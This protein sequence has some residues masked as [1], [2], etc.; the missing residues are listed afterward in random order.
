VYEVSYSKINN[1]DWRQTY[2]L[3]RRDCDIDYIDRKGERRIHWC[4]WI[5]W[6][7]RDCKGETSVRRRGG[8]LGYVNFHHS[9]DEGEPRWFFAWVSG[10]RGESVSNGKCYSNEREARRAVER[11]H[12]GLTR[13]WHIG[14][15]ASECTAPYISG[16]AIYCLP[17]G[18]D[19]VQVKRDG[20][21][22][23]EMRP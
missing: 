7:R 2:A 15:T 20:S 1:F 11:Y 22:V 16:G 4:G 18:D 12:R 21:V 10:P 14:K 19:P 13:G 8:W 3:S 23:V 5:T 6:R 17:R 9:F